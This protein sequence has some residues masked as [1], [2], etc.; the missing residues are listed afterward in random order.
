MNKPL[1]N[2]GFIHLA[3][4]GCLQLSNV[5][6]WLDKWRAALASGE[7]FEAEARVR[8]ADGEYCWFLQRNVPLRDETGKIVKRYGTGIN[9]TERKRAEAA[10]QEARAELERVTRVTTMGE[11]AASIAHEVNQPL[12]GESK[13]RRVIP[14][15][16]FHS[17]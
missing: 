6:E 16:G 3:M 10:L 5:M 14:G 1:R 12:A 11:L 2:Q 15:I 8:R 9:I 13:K 4:K 7:P 17:S